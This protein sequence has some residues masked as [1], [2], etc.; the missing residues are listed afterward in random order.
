V[1]LRSQPENLSP[2][3]G[4]AGRCNAAIGLLGKIGAVELLSHRINDIRKIGIS[5]I[6]RSHRGYTGIQMTRD[7]DNGNK[8]KTDRRNFLAECGRF[9][10]VTPPVVSLMLSVGEKAQA[11]DLATSGTTRTRT[12]RTRTYTTTKISVSTTP[13]S[14]SATSISSTVTNTEASLIEMPESE[15]KKTLATVIDS[16]GLMKIV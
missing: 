4:F 14:T 8:P 16:M 10:A 2:L 1:L 15:R 5:V 9:A 11:D 3:S 13:T 7:P 12:T 6:V